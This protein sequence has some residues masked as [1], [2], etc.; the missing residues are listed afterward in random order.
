VR[1]LLD[2]TQIHDRVTEVGR[3]LTQDFERQELTVIGVLTGSLVFLADLI[4]VIELPL[5]LGLVQAS[6]YRGKST[7]AGDLELGMQ[8]LPPLDDRAVLL[9]DDI[10]DT[11]RTLE[12]L[13]CE[14]ESR[15]VRSIRSVVLL[16]KQGRCEVD[17]RPDYSGFE[18]PDE[19]VVGYGLDYDGKY[20]H[21]PYVA[22]LEEA[23]L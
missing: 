16:T 7:T 1:T 4:R 6:S 18:I 11:G 22:C 10:F 21:L 5:E 20:R 19:F 14:F 8:V 2:K 23:D 13:K 17:Y 9:V 15:G 12:L 3:Q